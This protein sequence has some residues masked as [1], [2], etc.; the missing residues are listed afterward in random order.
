MRRMSN[1]KGGLVPVLAVVSV[2]L[3]GWSLVM[4]HLGTK[5]E[6]PP[7]KRSRDV[8]AGD[9]EPAPSLATVKFDGQRALGYLKQLCD[10]GPRVSGSEAMKK[11]QAIAKAHFEKHGAKV[12]LQKFTASQVSQFRPVELV[13]VIA[14]WQ[15]ERDKRVIICTHYDTR[16]RADQ[17]PDPSKWEEPFL[18]ANDGTAG[19]AWLMELAHHMKDLPTKVGVDFVLFD[20]EEYVFDGPYNSKDKYFLGSDHFAGEYKRVPPKHRYTAAVLL[21]M[22]AGRNPSFP[23]EQN[24]YFKAQALATE[25]WGIAAEQGAA[26]FKNQLGHTVS[27]DHLALN[28]VGIPAVDIIDFDYPHW[29]RLSDK[30][31]NCS[32][33]TMEEVAKV[34]TVWLQRTH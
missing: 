5:A 20:G 6:P 19:V 31:E 12:E 13:N 34:L 1:L 18:S 14:S 29:H 11:Q 24:S 3:I 4:P 8:F 21:D 7:A 22:A 26:A 25:I 27:D 33:N 17:E 23:F 15:P 2:L 30:P 28:R 16:P 10:L 9:R 32:A